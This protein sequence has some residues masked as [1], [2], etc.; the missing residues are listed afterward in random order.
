M[1]DV[2]VLMTVSSTSTSR[3]GDGLDDVVERTPVIIRSR[4]PKAVK[5]RSVMSVTVTVFL[6]RKC[7]VAPYPQGF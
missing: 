5:C 6:L 2:T 3:F 7:V 4:L 1:G